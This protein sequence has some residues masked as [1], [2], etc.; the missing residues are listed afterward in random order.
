MIEIEF[1]AWHKKEKKA[2]FFSRSYNEVGEWVYGYYFKSEEG[3]YIIPKNSQSPRDIIRVIPESV[4]QYTGLKDNKRT[5]EYPEGQ[6]IYKGD[7]VK[8][9]RENGFDFYFHGVCKFG[10]AYVGVHGRSY[11]LE[12]GFYN[13][14]KDTYVIEPTSTENEVIGNVWENKEL[15]NE[16]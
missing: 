10:S 5:K 7:I 8:F 11:F 12:A 16:T 4:G 14:S 15:L 3:S 13:E 6:K 1:R 9:K 2:F